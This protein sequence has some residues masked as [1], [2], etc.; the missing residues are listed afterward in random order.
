MSNEFKDWLQENVHRFRSCL[1][2]IIAGNLAS[3]ECLKMCQSALDEAQ[4]TKTL[5]KEEEVLHGVL[6][7]A[8]TFFRNDF[9]PKAIEEIYD[10]LNDCGY[11]D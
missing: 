9:N 11:L 10:A 7:R 2:Y 3:E 4:E 5:E 8:Y 6:S 1:N